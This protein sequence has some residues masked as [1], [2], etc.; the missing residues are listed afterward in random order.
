MTFSARAA[1]IAAITLGIAALIGPVTPGFAFQPD[2]GF[3][4][5]AATSIPL[6]SMT[7][8]RPVPSESDTSQD[9]NGDSAPR[10]GDVTDYPSLAV[11]AAAQ[12]VPAA[13]PE[14]LKCLAGAI[15]F[16]A[17]GEPLSG[18]LAVAD[19]IL[20]RAKSGRFPE[21]VCSV[22]TQPGQFSFVRG[23][24]MPSVTQGDAYRTAVSIAR[25]ALAG[26]WDSPAPDAL[27][28]HARG[29]ATGGRM[30]K[31]ASIGNHVFFR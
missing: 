31:I 6:T 25:V 17:K 16:E 23:G 7:A 13:M 9:A 10:A 30:T 8:A 28:F 4:R 26:A 11:A 27:F 22:V 2:D 3:D 21:S 19:V 29:V 15:Y 24:R 14:E 1:T 20:N 18:Q 12:D 5:M